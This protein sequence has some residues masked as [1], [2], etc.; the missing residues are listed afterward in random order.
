MATPTKTEKKVPSLSIN[1]CDSQETLDSLVSN[2]MVNEDEPYFV[3]NPIP[4]AANNVALLGADGRILDSKKQLTPAGIGAASSS[5]LVDMK[6]NFDGKTATTYQLP[7]VVKAFTNGENILEFIPANAITIEYTTDGGTTWIDYN[8]SDGEKIGL[9]DVLYSRNLYLGKNTGSTSATDGLRV[10][11]DADTANIYCIGRYLVLYVN[12]NCTATLETAYRNTPTVFTQKIQTTARENTAIPLNSLIYGNYNTQNHE[13]FLRL[14]LMGTAGGATYLRHLHMYAG[15][16]WKYP[17]YLARKNHLYSWDLSQN[18]TFPANIIATNFIGNLNGAATSLVD[19]ENTSKTVKIAYQGDNL[20]ADNLVYLSGFNSSG[21]IKPAAWAGVKSK[22]ELPAMGTKAA[23]ESLGLYNFTKISSNS[24][25]NNLTTCGFYTAA[26]NAI[27]ATLSNSP[28]TNA[29]TMRVFNVTGTTAK[30]LSAAY[31]Y[32]VQ[33]ITD[34]RNNVYR[35]EINTASSASDVTYTVWYH[36][37][38]T[39]SE[40]TSGNWKYRQWQNGFKEAWYQGTLATTID[41]SAGNNIYF[42]SGL[43]IAYP[44]SYTNTPTV[45][46]SVTAPG[47]MAWPVLAGETDTSSASFYLVSNYSQSSQTY[48][49]NLYIAG[50]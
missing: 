29:F 8:A 12:R 23:P 26:S 9:C 50:Y 22:L 33:E 44:F 46:I 2:N 27:A 14:T 19:F 15:Q 40:G 6:I 34:L 32:L 45:N 43:T 36:V 28:T 3:P 39:Y 13:T 10:T 5:D 30:D 17:S 37:A 47:L 31:V 41:S 11:I 38:A 18:A 35:R 49:V 25:L 42:K 24:D 4:S 20:T 1:Y 7:P 16:I 48:I 21:N